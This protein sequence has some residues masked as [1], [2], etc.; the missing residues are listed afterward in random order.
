M[1]QQILPQLTEHCQMLQPTQRTL[2]TNSS[3]STDSPV[4]QS[5]YRRFLKRLGLFFFKTH[6][7][8]R[9]PNSSG[10]SQKDRTM[11][12]LSVL[13]GLMACLLATG[14]GIT[15]SWNGM[16]DMASRFGKKKTESDALVLDQ[17]ALSEGFQKARGGFTTKGLQN[18]E[19][20]N[21]AFARWKEDMGQYVESKRRYHE[22]LT[23]NPDCLAAR[24]GIARIERETGR[25][26]Q[27][28]DILLAAQKQHPNDATVLIELGRTYGEREEWDSAI[29]AFREAVDLAPDDQTTRYELGV[30]LACA[31]RV[32]EA[33]PHLKF[34][35]GDSAAYYNVGYR[36]HERGRSAEAVE[37]LER[38]M[39][40]HPDDR[41]QNV[42]GELL[43]ELRSARPS[44]PSFSETA[45]AS[46][47]QRTQ[48]VGPR[49]HAASTRFSV[50]Q[51]GL[52]SAQRRLPV[53]P[54]VTTRQY[55]APPAAA[56]SVVAPALK[57][58]SYN[59]GEAAPPQWS[60]PGQSQQ[61]V[62]RAGVS[63]TQWARSSQPRVPVRTTNYTQPV[64][65]SQPVNPP[66]WRR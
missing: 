39:T 11:K 44:S 29:R 61:P 13:T 1:V 2:T 24:L 45:V 36:L 37:W 12:R 20:T 7:Y 23:A 10:L 41:T 52:P 4:A 56:P 62:S 57:V 16:S 26:D 38:A 53:Q 51:Q 33:L 46:N 40:A 64:D 35:V 47:S 49:I 9:F 25:F 42:A 34:A 59:S 21:L 66:A 18:P 65:Q 63:Q 17:E 8:L 55:P 31:N 32:S 50:A 22:I 19:G 54:A 48:S 30:A 58:A 6:C 3:Q 27:C 60:G 15:R 5:R 43:A 14:C 28:R